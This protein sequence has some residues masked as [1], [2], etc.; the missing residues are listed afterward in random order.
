MRNLIIAGAFV[1]A[2]TSVSAG[3]YS[4][5]VVTPDVVMQETVKAAGDDNWVGVLMTLLTI[6]LAIAK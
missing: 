2:A 4:D 3:G 5:P 6:G 1:L